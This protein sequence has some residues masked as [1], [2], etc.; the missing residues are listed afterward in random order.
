M[1]TSRRPPSLPDQGGSQYYG[2][3]ENTGYETILVRALQKHLSAQWLCRAPPASRLPAPKRP[4][5]G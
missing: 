1:D 4:P 3:E 2:A 5:Q